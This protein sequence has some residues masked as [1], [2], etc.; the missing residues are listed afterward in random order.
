MDFIG[1]KIDTV[2]IES[3]IMNTMDYFI[4]HWA[5]PIYCFYSDRW[6]FD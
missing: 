6:C 3:N 4:K 2:Y 1:S 5:I